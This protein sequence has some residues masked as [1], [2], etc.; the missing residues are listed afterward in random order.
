MEQ[1]SDYSY[2]NVVQL[3][4]SA[5]KK[6][7]ANIFLWMFA[8]LGISALCA[9]WFS[10]DIELLQLLINTD[11]GRTTL[12]GKIAMFSPLAFVLLMSFGLNRLSYPVLTSLFVAY[13]A[14]TGISLSFILL[15][16]TASSIFGC[17]ITASLLFGVMA[18]AGYTTNQDLT[19]FGSILFM[20]LIG[21][22]IASVVNFFLNS[23]QLDYIISFVGVAIFVGLTAYDV[24]KLKRI[25]EGLEYGEASSKKMII[26]GALTLYLDFLNM[27]LFLLRLFGGRK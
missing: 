20:L 8:A 5:S 12:L 9:F 26:M 21:I 11:T 19:K 15:V 17:F 22:L 24:Q 16:F 2:Q 10:T 7:M 13:A 4:S 18:I 25:S 3:E 27:F 14:L 6:F 1:N 23:S